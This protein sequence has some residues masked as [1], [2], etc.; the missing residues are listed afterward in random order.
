MEVYANELSIAEDTFFR[1]DYIR[2]LVEIYKILSQN[3]IA[4]CRINNEALVQ[5]YNSLRQ[6]PQKRNLLNFVYSFFHAPFDTDEAV[7]YCAVEYISHKWSYN[8]CECIGLTY[9]ALMDSLAISFT[10]KEWEAI[11]HISRD[12]KLIDVRNAS[13]QSQLMEHAEWI[14]SLKEVVLIE[15]D[16]SVKDKDIHL[17]HDHGEDVLYAFSKR[18]CSS[19]YV[20]G[21][22]NSLPFNPKEKNFIHSINPS[23]LIECVLCWT[24][25]GYGIAVQTTG[26][27]LRETEKIAEILRTCYAD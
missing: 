18:I 21:I 3:G 11:V 23:G 1:F 17:R 27:N 22:V 10:E 6:D 8:G 4:S 13:N 25:K 7:D 19:S 15:T 26:R 20:V 12:D 9:A 14:D 16:I 5:L 2:N 24:D